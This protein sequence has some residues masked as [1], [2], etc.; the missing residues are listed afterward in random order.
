MWRPSCLSALRINEST[1]T[2][3]TEAYNVF[4]HPNFAL[5]LNTNFE[6][7]NFGQIV[8]TVSNSSDDSARVLQFALRLDF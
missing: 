8:S 2:C 6:A 5:P 7:P 1:R 3:R 4:N